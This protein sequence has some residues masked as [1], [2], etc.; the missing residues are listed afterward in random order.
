MNAKKPKLVPRIVVSVVRALRS[1]RAAFAAFIVEDAVA[2]EARVVIN[3]R[4]IVG[5]LTEDVV[6]DMLELVV[7]VIELMVIGIVV[8]VP[9]MTVTVLDA[10]AGATLR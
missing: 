5:T 3:P 8:L 4:L 6:D 9:L 2:L 7:L 10:V 1:E